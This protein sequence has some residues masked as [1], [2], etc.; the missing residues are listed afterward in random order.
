MSAPQSGGSPTAQPQAELRLAATFTGGVSLAVWMGGMAREMNLLLAASRLRRG[1]VVADTTEQGRR[2]RDLY[3]KL[4]ELLNIDCSLDVISGTSAG[5]IN[6]VI[7]GLANVQRLD[8]DGLRQL[9]FEEGSLGGLLRNPADGPPMTSLLYGDKALLDGL[10]A[11]LEKLAASAPNNIASAHDPTRVFITTTLLE[12][13]PSVFRDE[14]GVAVNDVD[15]H[16]LFSFTDEQLTPA[17]VPA[18]A[19]A[20]R[21]SASFPLAFEAGFVPI[22][23]TPD[24]AHPDMRPF[25]TGNVTS[26]F[27]A[28]GGLLANRPLGQALQAVFDRPADREVR[29]VLAFV[30]PTVTEAEKPPLTD[31][32]GLFATLGADVGA[33]M[34]QSISADLAAISAHNQQVRA[35]NDV[36]RQL[37]VMGM[38]MERLGLPFYS[39]YRD[40]RT[41]DIARVASD[42]VMERVPAGRLASDGSPLGFG[43]AAREACKT[44]K[45]AAED[46]VQPDLPAIGDYRGMNAAGRETLDEGRAT[47]LAILRRTY[48]LTLSAQQKEELGRLRERVAEAMP[49]R[50][51]ADDTLIRGFGVGPQVPVAPELTTLKARSSSVAQALAKA[52]MK[53]QPER[54]PWAQLAEVVIAMSRLV[55]PSGDGASPGTDGFVEDL[56]GYLTGPDGKNSVDLVAA[57]LFDLQVAR[58]AIQPDGVLADQALELIQMSSDTGTALDPRDAAAKKLTGLKMHHFGAF[59]KASWR[60]NDWMWGR[61]DGAGWLVHVLLDP[62]RLHQ[63]ATE[64]GDPASF[65]RKLRQQLEQIAGCPAPLGVW[66]PLLPSESRPTREEMAFLDGTVELPPSLPTTATWVAGGLQ[67]LIAGEELVHVAEQVAVDEHNQANEKD[68]KGFRDAYTAA[69][70]DTS[71][72]VVPVAQAAQVLNACQIPAEEFSA[73]YHTWLFRRTVLRAVA[74]AVKMLSEAMPSSIRLLLTPARGAASLAAKV[75]GLLQRFT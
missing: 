9:W 30:V 33:V 25:M 18:L 44:A 72:P 34:A 48:R 10:R 64:S 70:G 16:G 24:S 14:Y 45:A 28:D 68:T 75:G 7:L 37:A 8:L 47:V 1:E 40:R 5:G 49:Q 20:A 66:E 62:Q 54:E 69:M 55:A 73:E 56:L 35:R 36:R 52:S 53:I 41:D 15:H 60:A 4:L 17:N 12:G 65:T 23:T 63:L 27:V 50:D 67:R 38:S 57:R 21:C 2:V 19:L 46:A 51:T 29:R 26:Q 39:R 31:P 32:P 6:A 74:V 61:L 13:K 22:G 43:S 71:C 59:Y 11:G 42:E 3:A 58:Y